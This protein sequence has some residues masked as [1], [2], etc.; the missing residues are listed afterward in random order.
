MTKIIFFLWL[1]SGKVEKQHDSF[2]YLDYDDG[3]KLYTIQ[4][5]PTIKR[6]NIYKG[7]ILNFIRTGAWV[8]NGE[9]SDKNGRLTKTEFPVDTVAYKNKEGNI[10]EFLVYGKGKKRYVIDEYLKCKVYIY[11]KKKLTDFNNN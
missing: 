10:K 1:L 5:S 3:R 7:E 2:G 9:F 8:T 6:T 4:V 11:R